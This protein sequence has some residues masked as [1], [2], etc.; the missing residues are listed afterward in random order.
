MF[1]L[2][3]R[4]WPWRP[5]MGEAAEGA[6]ES[7]E[8][9]PLKRSRRPA[10]AVSVT[11]SGSIVVNADVADKL[12]VAGN[13]RQTL[14]EQYRKVA[15]ML[16]HAQAERVI[17]VVLVSS[18]LPS[19]GK[20]LT[21]ANLALTLSES[22]RRR[23]L[24]IDADLRRPSVHTV[25]NLPNTE[26]LGD[27]LRADKWFK[28]P[29]TAVTDRL[30][31]LTA[32]RPDSDPMSGLISDR[33]RETLDDFAARFEWVIIDTPPVDLLPDA[34]LMAK[35]ADVVLLVLRAGGT[36][37]PVV[38]R[39]VES[40]GRDRIFGVILN[41]VAARTLASGYYYQYYGHYGGDG[42]N[43]QKKRGAAAWPKA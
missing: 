17:K 36:P 26:G 12:A 13:S 35:M 27:V 40:L 37:Y 39:A 15:A 8:P 4:F 29:L 25:F 14:L 21:T 38:R 32:G 31:V 1:S 34:N 10:P 3:A 28:P 23:V 33:M 20:T 41:R 2:A 7:G 19:E 22:Y 24:L 6:F 18:A 11:V 9:K 43:G 42:Q 5:P 30:S 16:H